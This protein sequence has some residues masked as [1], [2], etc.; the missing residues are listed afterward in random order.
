MKTV[1]KI[2][3]KSYLGP[4]AVTLCI[5]VFIL[6][7]QFL[8][9]Y[10][11]DLVGKGLEWQVI[12]QLLFYASLTLVPMALPL[13]ILLSS[14]MTFGNL[15]ENYELVALKSAGL[16]LYKIM[17]PLIVLTIF[18][19]GVAFYFSNN[20]LPYANLKMMSLLYDVRDQKAAL[21]IK[22][23]VFYNGID[24]YSIRVNKKEKDGKT[25][26]DIMIYDHT[27]G[28]GNNKVIIAESGTME[29]SKDKMFLL[30]DLFKGSSYEE[31]LKNNSLK[32]IPSMI[33]SVF[34]E[35]LIRF[36][37]KGFKLTRTDE[38]LFKHNYQMLKLNQLVFTLDSLNNRKD[39]SIIRFKDQL[40]QS[41]YTRSNHFLSK[42]DSLHARIKVKNKTRQEFLSSN[43]QKKLSIIETAQNI[44]R[45]TQAITQT[46]DEEVKADDKSISLHSAEYHR[47]FT[48]SI[49]CFILFFIGAPL[50]AIIRKGGLGMPVVVS[51]VFFIL[52]HVL[53]I[54]GEK[55]VKEG[56]LPA[57]EGMWIAPVVL[58][59]IGVFLTYKASLD[60]RLFDSEI[61]LRPFR[62]LFSAKTVMQG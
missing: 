27:A 2:V 48:L 5:S 59:P 61:Y 60:S 44:A 47:K 38:S 23:S 58:F 56:A 36:D 52:F 9:K 50:G 39:S 14:I 29:I 43:P 28:T 6:V 25:L 32:K 19:C 13:A 1:H 3:L 7:M 31:T 22:E 42:T 16:S 24:G 45:S 51:V 18:L 49:A 8:W 37:L 35:Q 26:H 33:R 12:A 17:S 34:E 20:I 30:I 15:G 10:I 62:K 21:K 40:N 53:S 41:Y 55:L 54:T 11:D 57:Y 46:T 4:F